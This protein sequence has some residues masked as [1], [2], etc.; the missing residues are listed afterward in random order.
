MRVEMFL[1]SLCF[2]ILPLYVFSAKK[3]GNGW[4]EG[5]EGKSF[6]ENEM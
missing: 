2:W 6:L 1:N 3:R 5:E 4:K